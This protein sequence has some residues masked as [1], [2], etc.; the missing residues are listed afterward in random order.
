[1]AVRKADRPDALRQFLRREFIPPSGR[2]SAGGLTRIALSP[3]APPAV[4]GL[5][6]LAIGNFVN[7]AFLARWFGG[8][9]SPIFFAPFLLFIPGLAN[10]LSGLWSFRARDP[11][12]TLTHAGIWGPFFIGYG[13][14]WIFVAAG[15][16]SAPVAPGP[17]PGLAYVFLALAISSWLAALAAFGLIFV[18]IAQFAVLGTAAFL[19]FLAFLIGSL[20]LQIAGGWLFIVASWIAWYSATAQLFASIFGIELL[21]IG[22]IKGQLIE[23]SPVT[24]PAGE[25]GVLKGQ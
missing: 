4:L 16:I 6:S 10:F 14:F 1:M 13:I 7:G 3:I 23:I 25:P 20:P 17:F 19:E 5:Y 22:R 15:I 21:P 18:R 11:H 24:D 9:R 8:P 2:G 12:G